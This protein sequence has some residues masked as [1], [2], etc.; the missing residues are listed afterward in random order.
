MDIKVPDN[1][2]GKH[3]MTKDNWKNLLKG[4]T[5]ISETTI[6]IKADN[7]DG[8]GMAYFFGEFTDDGF[9]WGTS[10]S[11]NSKPAYNRGTVSLT[12]DFLDGNKAHFTGK[13]DSGK[14]QK[15]EIKFT[16]DTDGTITDVTVKFTSG[17]SYDSID[18]K[19]GMPKEPR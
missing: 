11:P 3:E 17:T 16:I 5:I 7:S 4:R 15:G 12:G 13:D 10:Y 14:E 19:C 6:S 9:K 2:S 8:F 1:G 18:I